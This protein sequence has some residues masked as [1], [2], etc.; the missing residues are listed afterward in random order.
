MLP[1]LGR[2]TTLD[3]TGWSGECGGDGQQAIEN[4]FR[5]LG[6]EGWWNKEDGE[7]YSFQ[8]SIVKENKLVLLNITSFK[9]LW[10]IRRWWVNSWANNCFIICDSEAA[11]EKEFVVLREEERWNV[12]DGEKDSYQNSIL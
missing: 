6:E 1:R 10:F 3:A 8:K 11:I 5:N 12:V 2:P 9:G 7:K 4:E